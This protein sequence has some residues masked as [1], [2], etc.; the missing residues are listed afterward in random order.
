[1]RER[2][3]RGARVPAQDL[4]HGG[5]EVIV[6]DGG[7][8]PTPAREGVALPQEEGV[9]PLRRETFQEQRPRVAQPPR[10]ERDLDARPIEH[11]DGVAE[12]E[13]GPLAGREGQGHVGGLSPRAAELAHHQ[14]HRRLADR[15]ALTPEFHPHPVC[16]PALFRRPPL[17]PVVLSL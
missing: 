17:Q 7:R 16:R 15:D 12:V 9:L 8:D 1:V 14:A 13:L 3:L 6:D 10:Q 11:D 5:L 2:R 4:P